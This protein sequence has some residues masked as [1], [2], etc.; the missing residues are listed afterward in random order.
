VKPA[1]DVVQ[2]PIFPKPGFKFTNILW[3]AFLYE[4]VLLI[5]YAMFLDHSL[6]SKQF[7]SFSTVLYENNYNF[8]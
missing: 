7:F 3:A 4:I 5:F 8:G 1:E 2:P 6:K